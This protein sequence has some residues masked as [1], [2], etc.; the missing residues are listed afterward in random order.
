MR[1][2]PLAIPSPAWIVGAFAMVFCPSCRPDPRP[3]PRGHLPD[4]QAARRAVESS[5]G[6]WRQS[7]PLD[8]TTTTIRPV[9]FVDQQRQPGRRLRE[10]AVLGEAEM[11][12]CRRFQ[13]RLSM[14][15]PDESIITA[16][17][18]FGRDPIWVYRA[19]DFDM[20]MHMDKTMMAAQA[21]EA[22]LRAAGDKPGTGRERHDHG[23]TGAASGA[24]GTEKATP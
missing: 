9:V 24:G 16:Y 20:I 10:F 8:L 23:A 21:E 13:V 19:E 18:V 6:E 11:D 7:P 22:R 15:D 14:A 1:R 5:L 12:G 17:Y 2:R 3:D 4:A